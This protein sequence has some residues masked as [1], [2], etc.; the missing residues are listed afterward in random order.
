VKQNSVTKI[1]VEQEI[2]RNSVGKINVI[3]ETAEK[4]MISVQ[5]CDDIIPLQQEQS[6]VSEDTVKE[7][8]DKPK[9]PKKSVSFGTAW[10]GSLVTTKT[11]LNIDSD[12]EIP[13]GTL[14]RLLINVE[15]IE[16]LIKPAGVGMDRTL[17]ITISQGNHSVT[18]APVHVGYGISECHFDWECSL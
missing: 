12:I 5:S 16:E 4:T 17:E 14:G 13:E 8:V 10:D 3:P 1:Y 9:V 15:K 7:I 2:P 11:I 18:S 6:L